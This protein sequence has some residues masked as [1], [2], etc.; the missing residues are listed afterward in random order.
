MKKPTEIALHNDELDNFG[1][2]LELIHT[3]N[4]IVAAHRDD[5]YVFILQQKGEFLVEI[6]F[7]EM[8]LNGASLC[9]VAPGQVHRYVKWKDIKGWFVFVEVNLVPEQYREIFDT[10]QHIRQVVA[11]NTN[12]V[13]FK[14]IPIL[15]QLLLKEQ[16]QLNK[17]IISYQIGTIIGITASKVIQSKTSGQINNGQRYHIVNQFKQLIRNNYKDVK[18]VQQY[19]AL[20]NISPLYLNEVIKEITG[21]P[22]S[23]WIQQEIVLEAKRLLN[24]TVLDVKQIAFEL[25]YED[26]AYFSRFFKKNTGTTAVEFRVKNHHMSNHSH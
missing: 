15:E 10:Y 13:I 17:S 21:F 8:T 14:S 9:F 19:A 5:H 6:D 3:C 7:S 12:D 11:L 16:S 20:L 24:Y 25:G 2:N 1:V 18:Q 22:A 23:Y 26:H 4:S